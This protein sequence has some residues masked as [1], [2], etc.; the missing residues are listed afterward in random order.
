MFNQDYEKR[1]LRQHNS[2]MTSSSS[3]EGV[4]VPAALPLSGG[5]SSNVSSV[6]ATPARIVSG[7][8][9]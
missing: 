1:L 7:T 4:P 6:M 2:S 3:S 8:L 9:M 5:G